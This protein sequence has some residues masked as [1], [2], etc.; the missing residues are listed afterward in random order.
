M[1]LAAKDTGIDFDFGNELCKISDLN[2]LQDLLRNIADSNNQVARYVYSTHR[3]KLWS[4]LG[5]LIR[6]FNL[7]SPVTGIESRLQ[8]DPLIRGKSQNFW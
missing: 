1:I 3:E 5:D 7:D 2:M 6:S 4:K 8:S